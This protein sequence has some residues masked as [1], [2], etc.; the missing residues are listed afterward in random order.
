VGYL[1]NIILAIFLNSAYLVVWFL[2][3]AYYE[4]ISIVLPSVFKEYKF[5]IKNNSFIYYA[6]YLEIKRNFFSKL[7]SC[8]FCLGFWSSLICGILYNCILYACVI[9]II[10][11]LLFFM[12]KKYAAIN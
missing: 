10:S 7:F 11:L 2:T 8:P 1:N 12:V 5:Y 3:N 6:E 9:Y 4:Y